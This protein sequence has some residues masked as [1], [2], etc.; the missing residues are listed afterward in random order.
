M[1]KAKIVRCY[2][3]G[4]R[5]R[6]QA[7][8]QKTGHFRCASCGEE[9]GFSTSKFYISTELSHFIKNNV[10][11]IGLPILAAY[12]YL[13]LDH[14]QSITGFLF[15][16][17]LTVASICY[18]ELFHAIMSLWGG[19]FSVWQRGYLRLSPKKYFEFKTALLLPIVFLLFFGVFFQGRQCLSIFT[20]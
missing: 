5:N 8:S 15:L 4:R 18:H 3:C 9:V 16:F 10:I 7:K 13:S 11:L 14:G 1:V 17:F 6:L 12:F 20:C 2:S 19:D